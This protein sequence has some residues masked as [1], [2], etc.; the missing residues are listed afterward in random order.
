MS[1]IY[2]FFTFR[3]FIF[4]LTL[5]MSTPLLHGQENPMLKMI[6]MW[7]VEVY[8][9]E[10]AALI[11]QPEFTTKMEMTFE[12][13]V[14]KRGIIQTSTVAAA[15][16]IQ[17]LTITHFYDVQKNEGHLL[18]SFGTGIITYPDDKNL[19][20]KQYTFGGELLSLQNFTSISADTY[21]GTAEP[22]N[23]DQKVKV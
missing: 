4:L 1:N 11:E 13:S 22:Q 3:Y 8:K 18:G 17:Q 15:G 10:P 12:L 23:A 21:E 16:Q 14:D 19:V 2:S 9:T 6:G 5:S 7:D 20:I